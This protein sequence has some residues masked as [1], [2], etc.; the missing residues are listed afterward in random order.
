MLYCERCRKLF[1]DEGYGGGQSGG[2]R[3]D[4]GRG[5][6]GGQ[7]RKCRAC[8]KA[9]LREP[10]DNDPVFILSNNAFMSPG[11]EDILKRNGI[12]CLMQGE[13]GG[14]IIS[15]LGYVFEHYK[16]YV[17]YGAYEKSRELL[18]DY[19]ELGHE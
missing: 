9:V 1:D 18:A 19:M 15:Q 4:S 3:G 13:I 14:G 11:I 5:A 12:P 17:P 10:A 2:G 16:F 6:A 7:K 8:G